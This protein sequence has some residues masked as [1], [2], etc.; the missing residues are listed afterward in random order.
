MNEA[1][2]EHMKFGHDVTFTLGPFSALYSQVYHPALDHLILIVSLIFALCYLGALLYAAGGVKPAPAI[3]FLIFLGWFAQSRDA[4]M[5]SY[6]LLLA[7]CAVK[8]CAGNTERQRFNLRHL[9]FAAALC[10][11]LGLLP[12][13][14]GNMIIVCFAMVLLIV[15]YLLYQRR[16]AFGIVTAVVPIL[17]LLFFWTLAAQPLSGLADYVRSNIQILS[18]YTEAMGMQGEFRGVLAYLPDIEILAFLI[19]AGALM[20][21]LASA[22][23]LANASKTFLCACFAL[24]LS[25]G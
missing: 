24:F 5:F 3:I 8:F 6:P 22:K 13:V 18:G 19:A 9:L 4:L 14:K 16:V 20:W 2:A 10:V 15:G 12:L 7:V 11:P 23:A 1:A 25:V 17:S 21:N